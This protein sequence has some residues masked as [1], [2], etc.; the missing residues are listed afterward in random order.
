MITVQFEYKKPESVAEAVAI[1]SEFQGDAVYLSGGTDL[2][3]RSR[4]SGPKRPVARNRALAWGIAL[5][6][7]STA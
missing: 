5:G 6:R 3:P 7:W 2:L 4:R 1:Q